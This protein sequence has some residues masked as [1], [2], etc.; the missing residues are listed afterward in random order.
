MKRRDKLL[1]AA[2]IWLCVFPS[3]LFVTYFFE[4]ASIQAPTWLRILISTAFTVPFIEFVVAP[5]VEKI[6]AEARD[7]TRS[8]LLASQAESAD[9][10]AP[11]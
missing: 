2:L 8:E 5:R 11:R 6:V 7:E 3:V 10:P 9:G 4:W 1:L